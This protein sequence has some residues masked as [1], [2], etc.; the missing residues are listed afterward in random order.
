VKDFLLSVT[1]GIM[2]RY[3]Y[4]HDLL[5][6]ALNSLKEIKEHPS[7]VRYPRIEPRL[8]SSL[9]KVAHEI[10]SV[11]LLRFVIKLAELNERLKK[12]DEHA[13]DTECVLD[14]YFALQD[15]VPR[16]DAEVR[17]SLT[18]YA[19]KSIGLFVLLCALVVVSALSLVR[20]A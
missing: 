10:G 5:E 4:A 20:C 2:A 15:D 8:L 17:K 12:T 3:E 1:P 7:T 9:E 11:P 14:T 19:A 13:G 18:T 16:L 6:W